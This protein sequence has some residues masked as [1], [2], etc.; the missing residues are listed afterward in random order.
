MIAFD[1]RSGLL[2]ALYR[3]AAPCTA[4][5]RHGRARHTVRIPP[6]GKELRTFGFGGRR[7]LNLRTERRRYIDTL[8]IRSRLATNLRRRDAPRAARRC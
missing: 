1:S 3:L 5:T 2:P 6:R 8:D 7:L 4:P